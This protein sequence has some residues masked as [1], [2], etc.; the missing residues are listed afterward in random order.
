M[1]VYA[2]GDVH[3]QLEKLEAA[4][5]RIA[6]DRRATGDHSA[7]VV[8]LGD[9][10]DRGPDSAGVLSLLAGGI[11]SGEPW[12][13]VLGNHDRLFSIFLADPGGRDRRLRE[14]YDWF[15]P[16]LGGAA[17]LASY[18]VEGAGRRPVEEVHREAIEAV[19]AAH[20]E[21]IS[22]ME[23]YVETADLILVH[24]GIRPGVDLAD[25]RED[26]LVWIR[27]GFLEDP[28]DHGRLVV[29]GHTTVE[30]P[31]H[32]GNRIN[33]DTGAGYG[34]ALTVAVFEGREAFVL[35]GSGRTPLRPP[36]GV[37]L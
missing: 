7:P 32:A 33:L 25:Q 9:L 20:R 6:A 12:R 31:M 16:A 4:H 17:T 15:H 1:R 10:C 26:D 5:D 23:R 37:S 3:G 14:E 34:R 18:G 8:H 28:S 29:H 22:G 21:L 36:V 24:A 2:I 13:V 19:P 11:A 30:N 27:E 35:T